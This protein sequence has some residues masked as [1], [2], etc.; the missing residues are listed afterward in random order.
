ME[1]SPSAPGG[2]RGAVLAAAIGA[3]SLGVLVSGSTVLAFSWFLLVRLSYVL[4][5]GISLRAQEGRNWYT[6]RYGAEGGYLRFRTIASVLINYDAVAIGLVCWAGRNGFPDGPHAVLRWTLGSPLV[7]LGLGIKAWAH[8]TLGEGGYWW[9]GS[10]LPDPGE[11]RVASG[12]YRWF[13]NPMY[14][15]GYLHAYGA[16]LILGS[17]PGA[18]AALTAQVLIL[19]M[20]H[21]AERPRTETLPA[22]QAA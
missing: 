10:F 14:T 11:H 2:A 18:L 19:S 7:V 5:V 12:P 22:R 6:N 17:L 9:K 3:C 4:F 13:H 20:N 16:A 8:R 1:S 21:L 15:V